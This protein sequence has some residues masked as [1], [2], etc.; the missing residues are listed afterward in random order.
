MTVTVLDSHLEKHGVVTGPIYSIADIAKDPHYRE[1]KMV[2]YMNDDAL[3]T[4]AVPGIVPRL[5][6]TEGDIAWLG[7]QELGS[8]NKEI[9]G[10][11]LGISDSEL[12][13]LSNDGII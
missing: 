3:G 2:R 7:P 12:D 8:H 10:S 5:T 13:E 6:E 11:L 4:I 9:Y 1:R